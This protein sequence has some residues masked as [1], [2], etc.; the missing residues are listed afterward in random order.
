MKR[1]VPPTRRSGDDL[2]A[3]LRN[4]FQA[5]IPNPWPGFQPPTRTQLA[6]RDRQEPHRQAPWVSRWTLAAAL[7]ILV[8]AGLLLP[9]APAPES[10]PGSLSTLGEGTAGRRVVPA[11]GSSATPGRLTPERG[12][13]DRVPEPPPLLEFPFQE[14][15]PNR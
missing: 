14:L 6:S 5:E 12:T 3:L 7:A 15:S 11:N 2:D 9:S 13:R 10:A 4:Y 8:M 1:A